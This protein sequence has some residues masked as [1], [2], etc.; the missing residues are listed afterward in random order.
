MFPI[1]IDGYSFI[2]Y[3][4]VGLPTNY[5]WNFSALIAYRE[6]NYLEKKIAH[7]INTFQTTLK[8]SIFTTDD[9]T[10]REKL[11]LLHLEN[12]LSEAK[13]VIK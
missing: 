7:E 3:F 9:T 13:K 12:Y 5:P 4:L 2:Y 6:Y 10:L 11:E 1:K 8:R